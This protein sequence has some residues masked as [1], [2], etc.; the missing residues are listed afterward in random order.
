MEL[1]YSNSEEETLGIGEKIGKRTDPPRVI[2]LYGELGSGKT[3]LTRG[4]AR[5][6]AV[7]DPSQVRSPSFTLV[8][9]YPASNGRV[10]H[11]D[12]YRLE[13]LRDLHSIDIE[14]ILCSP[15]IV[16][17][18]WAEKLLLQPKHPVTIRISVEPR[19]ARRRFEIEHLDD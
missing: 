4:L 19:T 3:V 17:V 1:R 16:I 18:E 2:L 12:L 9:E 11:I 13:G 6:L 8:N 5:G 7:A 15:F 14:E 10:Y